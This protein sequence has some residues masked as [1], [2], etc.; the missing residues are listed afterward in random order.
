MKNINDEH[1]TG[2]RA[3]FHVQDLVITNTLFDDGES[4]LKESK[5]LRVINSTFGWKYP[6]WYDR[7]VEVINTTWTETGRA[8]VW[9]T[10]DIR[11]N[12]CK[13]HGVKNFRRCKGITME[14]VDFTNALE[15]LW[16]CEDVVL[17]NVTV[18]EGPYFGM[19]MVN[20][21][22][23]HLELDGDYGFDGAKNVTITNS[24]LLTKDA[25][26]NCENITC[27]NCKI[28]GEYF[29]WNSKNITLIDCEIESHQ[30]FCYIDSLKLVNCK[31]P[32]TTLCF[33]YCTNIDADISSRVASI[34]NPTSG[35]IRCLGVDELIM[36]E[37]KVEPNETQIISK[38]W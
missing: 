5:N 27:I 15:T 19:N 32:K 13:I 17:N 3:L 14:S 1:F 38:E 6:L 33:E 30:G 8:G 35:I 24:V 34:K 26:W 7:N 22:I 20:G 10:N 23:D 2:E 37:N 21:R 25:F 16:N 12:N 9:Y 11:L 31:M 18:K 29:G 36:D 4:P 28:V